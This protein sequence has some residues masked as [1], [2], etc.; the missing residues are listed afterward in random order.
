MKKDQIISFN[1]IPDKIYGNTPFTLY[2]TSTSGLTVLYKSSNTS[3]IK[4]NNNRVIIVGLGISNITAYQS[5][6][7]YYNESN[8][9]TQKIIVLKYNV[10]LNSPQLAYNVNAHK[11]YLEVINKNK[12]NSNKIQEYNKTSY[13]RI[14]VPEKSIASE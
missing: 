5:G 7:N 13:S 14:Y 11:Y 4:I 9:I 3:V 1:K 6:N 10:Q 8:Q 12:I 2:G